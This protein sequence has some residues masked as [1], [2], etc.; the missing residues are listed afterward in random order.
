MIVTGIYGGLR[1]RNN[2]KMKQIPINEAQAMAAIIGYYEILGA[3]VERRNTGMAFYPD[4]NRRGGLR[5]VK[6]GTV[7]A[8]DLFILFE[9][10]PIFTEVKSPKEHEYLIK[11][12]TRIAAYKDMKK[13]D[14]HLLDQIQYLER[15]KQAGAIAFFAS[16]IE[17]V[18]KQLRTY[19]LIK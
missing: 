12:G 6:Y 13:K 18:E 4:K 17:D 2:M 7:G 3:Y 16:S 10:K 5:P 9:G 8:S 1:L 19:E 14:F 15:V 11:H